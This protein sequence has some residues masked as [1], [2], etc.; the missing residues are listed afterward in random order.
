VKA[1]KKIILTG[2]TRGI[3]RALADALIDRG[4]ILFG[5]GRSPRIH[6]PFPRLDG[7]PG[8]QGGYLKPPAFIAAL[9]VEPDRGRYIVN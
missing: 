7:L 4:H 9:A 6:R 8:K 1:N 3:G 2:V 5:C